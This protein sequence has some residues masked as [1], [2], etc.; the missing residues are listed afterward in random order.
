VLLVGYGDGADALILRR[1]DVVA[2]RRGPSVQQQIER[3]RLLSSY[4]RYARFRKLVRRES[5]AHD[6]ST[7][8]VLHRDQR[9]TLPLYGGAC[10]G[11]GTVQF[12][13]REVCIECGHRGL[14]ERR[15]SRRGTVFTFTHDHIYE[16]ADAPVTHAVVDLDGGG[17]IYV[18]MTDCEP[19]AVEID[20]P[21]ELAFRVYH[22]GSGLK[23][24]FWKAR[25]RA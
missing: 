21:V 6:L 24:Y 13:R 23:N 10:R 9:S 11:C 12:P 3:K 25:P 18:Q 14:D 5:P 1:T 19:E 2:E 4:G 7:P 22:E 16:A 20:L 8:V 17:R 15:L